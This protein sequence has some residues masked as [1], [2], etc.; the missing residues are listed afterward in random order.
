[1]KTLNKIEV[2]ILNPSVVTDAE[3][4]MVAMARMTQKGH[5]IHDMSDFMD[6]LNKPYS[7]T[8]VE[9]M[10][11]LPHPTIQK[12]GMVSIAVIGASRRFLAQITRHQNEVKFMSGS[13]QYSDYSGV[14][15]FCVP[16]E[17]IQYDAEHC[18]EITMRDVYLGSCANALG[19]YET[20]ASTVGRDA[21]GYA[22]PQGLR[23]VL[24]I[25]ATP[26]QWKHMISQRICNRNT[27][28]TKYVMLRCWEELN[29]LSVMFS[30]AGPSCIQL[31]HCAEGKM[32]CGHFLH[33]VPVDDYMQTYDK[34]LPSAILDVHFK[35]IRGDNNV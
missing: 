3:Q 19:D 13:L 23:N 25:S 33:D 32:S 24:V 11:D 21:A 34:S 12:F 18:E 8:T 16:Y 9:T 30:N 29:A 26:Y 35:Y 6:L 22:M 31:G 28:E 20:L 2:K 27:L 15:Q 5:A 10:S 14:A 4:M 7:D 1:V 17:V